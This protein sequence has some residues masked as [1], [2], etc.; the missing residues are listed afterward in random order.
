M[1]DSQNLS[2]ITFK[3]FNLA[4]LS[5]FPVVMVIIVLSERLV[6]DLCCFFPLYSDILSVCHFEANASLVTVRMHR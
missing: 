3:F 4:K 1:I 2:P 5:T 6:S